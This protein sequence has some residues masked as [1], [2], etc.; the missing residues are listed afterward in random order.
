MTKFKLVFT[1]FL[2]NLVPSPASAMFSRMRSAFKP[3]AARRPIVPKIA[4][5]AV[6]AG[7]L[8]G[9]SNML[10]VQRLEGQS[11][12]SSNDWSEKVLENRERQKAVIAEYMKN[13]RP[14][15]VNPAKYPD[16]YLFIK[17]HQCSEELESMVQKESRNFELVWDDITKFSKIPYFDKGRRERALIRL[18]QA[19]RMKL[20]FAALG[21]RR[22]GVADKCLC[23]IGNEWHVIAAAVTECEFKKY[24]KE[25]IEE[26]M[27]IDAKTGFTDWNRGNII[28]GQKGFRM[29]V[30]TEDRSFRRSICQP[31]RYDYDLCDDLA[32]EVTR[33]WFEEKAS[34]Y[35][36]KYEHSYEES[37]LN[38]PIYDDPDI[39]FRFVRWQFEDWQKE[40][41][42][43]KNKQ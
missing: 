24:S 36:K 14:I 41:A 2:F 5:L 12:T 35:Q 8:Y 3:F 28:P 4:G 26:M 30:D 10:R 20:A 11:A 31:G 16:L 38:N 27:I 13:G 17:K 9:A 22:Y 6:G 37:L 32:E 15:N 40:M 21:I 23:S 42:Q 1:L 43:T 25:E 19:R 33:E 29:I 7:A 34:K 39:D 18:E